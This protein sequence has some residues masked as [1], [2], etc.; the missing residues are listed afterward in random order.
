M[1]AGPHTPGVGSTGFSLLRLL[2]RSLDTWKEL[3]TYLEHR[4][5]DKFQLH[6]PRELPRMTQGDL[7]SSRSQTASQKQDA[8]LE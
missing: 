6:L 1:C 3:H 5:G 7:K 4:R 2:I 8:G